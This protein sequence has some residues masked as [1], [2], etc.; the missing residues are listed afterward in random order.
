MLNCSCRKGRFIATKHLLILS[1][2]FYKINALL[3]NTTSWTTW[4]TQVCMRALSH[5]QLLNMISCQSP[6]L[7]GKLSVMTSWRINT[8]SIECFPRVLAFFFFLLS[9]GIQVAS[10]LMD[11]C[12]CGSFTLSSSQTTFFSLALVRP[13]HSTEHIGALPPPRGW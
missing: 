4:T 3:Q 13:S 9:T 12:L 1:K 11:F 7:R 5:W 10:Y 6:Q 8:F 2:N